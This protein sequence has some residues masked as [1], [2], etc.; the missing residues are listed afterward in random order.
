MALIRKC[1]RCLILESYPGVS[2]NKNMECSFCSSTKGINSKGKDALRTDIE[3]ILHKADKHR[4]YDCLLGFSGGRDSSFLLNLLVSEF[5]LKILAFCSYNQMLPI[6][7]IDNMKRLTDQLGVDFVI[8]SHNYLKKCAKHNIL[9][10][11]NNPEP[12]SLINLCVGCRL[13]IHKMTNDYCKTKKIPILIWGGT[14]FEGM[15]YKTKIIKTNPLSGKKA[16]ILG[17]LNIIKRNP[18]LV[19]NYN[20][21]MIQMF[22]F[23]YLELWQNRFRKKNNIIKISP[24]HKYIKWDE[25]EINNTLEKIGWQKNPDLNSTWRGDCYIGPV[26]QYFYKKLLG[27]NDLDDHIWSLIRAG[28][29]TKEEGETRIAEENELSKE[30]MDF[31]LTRIGVDSLS[32]GKKLARKGIRTSL[33]IRTKR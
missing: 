21:F 3:S 6:T 19:L 32:F 24:F 33:K 12:A 7:T 17:Y 25:R 31:L 13:G 1:N 8:Q 15:N 27:Y 20:S 16:F 10:W 23:I 4:K 11:A 14:P 22:E 5:N 29:I 30:Y 9:S 28:Q 2:L 18:R 26:R